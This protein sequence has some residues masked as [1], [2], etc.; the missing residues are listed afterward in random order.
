MFGVEYITVGAYLT[1][2]TLLC[3]E[4]G[5]RERLPADDS[6]SIA[7]LEQEW[8]DGAWCDTC[9]RELPAPYTYDTSGG[10]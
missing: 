4:C 6:I 10:D 3:R 7:S 9:G 1:D 8:P 5:E 2:G